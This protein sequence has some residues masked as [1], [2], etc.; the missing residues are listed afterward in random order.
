[1]L[2]KKEAPLG[3]EEKKG[4][5]TKEKEEKKPTPKPVGKDKP[6]EVCDNM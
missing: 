5:N 4:G 1:M 6:A 3:K 2:E